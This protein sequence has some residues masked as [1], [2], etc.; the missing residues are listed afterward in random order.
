MTNELFTRLQYQQS[1]KNAVALFRFSK[2]G[3]VQNLLYSLKYKN[4]PE[5]GFLLGLYY[6]KQL[7]EEWIFNL[8]DALVPIPLH[9]RKMRRRGYNQSEEFARGLAQSLGVVMYPHALTRK[10]F[11][12]TQTKKNKLGR[13]E[14]VENVFSV[15]DPQFVLK[16]RIAL[17]DDVVTTGSTIE[18]ASTALSKSGCAELSVISIAYAGGK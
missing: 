13:W 3:K 7:S 15:T 10:R 6:G 1:I 4:R 2:N 9:S 14:N 11:T 12:E 17:V 18:A 16:K 5:I 8:P